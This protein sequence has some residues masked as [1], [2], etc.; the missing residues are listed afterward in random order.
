MNLA[1]NKVRIRNITRADIPLLVKWKNDPEIADLVRGAPINTT[2]EIESRRYEKG[3]SEYDTLRL[4]IELLTGSPIGFIS[5]GSIDKENRKAEVGMLIGE[6]R[7]WNQGFGT[8]ALVTLLRHLFLELGFHRVGLE[9]FEYNTRAKKVYEKIG[10]RVEGLERQGLYRNGRYF[11]IILMGILRDEFLG[12]YR[13]DKI[14][15]AR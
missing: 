14:V 6:K 13:L 3:L 15:Q 7:M 12:K 10:F 11:D 2:F 1:G 4:I 5:L 9:V 8:D